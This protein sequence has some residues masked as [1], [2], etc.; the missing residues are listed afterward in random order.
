[1][2]FDRLKRREFIAVLGGAAAAW[3]LAARAQQQAMPVVAV[4][5]S[6]GETPLWSA[7]RGGLND[8]GYFVGRNVVLDV[9]STD[10]YDQLPAL[11][12]D[13]VSG[14]PAVLVALGGPATPAAK[15]ATT[16]I[17][18]VFSIGGD[19]VELGF[20][21]SIGRPGGNITG[22]TFFTAHLLQKQVGLMR[23][24]L[25]KARA[26][27]VLVNPRNPRAVAD[28]ASVR[29]AAG[30][31]GIEVHTANA[32]SKSDFEAAFAA[33]QSTRIDALV[34]LGDPLTYLERGSLAELALRHAIPAMYFAREFPQVGGL[35][36]YGANSADA[37]RQAGRYTGRILRGEKA[38]DLPVVQPTKFELVVNLKTAKALGL[39][40]PQTLLVAAD[41][42]I[43]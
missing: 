17:P 40:V 13:L 43:E 39:T 30:S 12:A 19:P 1:M 26:F 14:E 24:L 8:A 28:M 16:A 27:G 35:V 15:A 33:F 32:S 23:E 2:Q 10:R 7:F 22:A 3:P 42:V 21:A 41:E 20:V 18:I 38:A 36:S 9:R 25:P 34:I 29:A 37:Y 5:D 4:L 6:V 31:L 11:A